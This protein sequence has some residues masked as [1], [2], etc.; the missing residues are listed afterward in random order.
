VEDLKEF[1][2]VIGISILVIGVLIAS[3]FIAPILIGVGVIFA[4]YI[5][6]RLLNEDP[7]D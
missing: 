1:F 7:D 3:V 6:L 2:Q 5:V 4:V